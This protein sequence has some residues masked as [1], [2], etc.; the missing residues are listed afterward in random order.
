MKDGECDGGRDKGPM[1]TEGSMPLSLWETLRTGSFPSRWLCDPRLPDTR[2]QMEKGVQGV[3]ERITRH[4]DT[5]F[6]LYDPIFLEV[7]G[8]SFRVSLRQFFVW[9]VD[10]G[11]LL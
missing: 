9:R 7:L 2:G 11:K 6:T 5:P 10:F 1:H 8:P 3:V 4:S